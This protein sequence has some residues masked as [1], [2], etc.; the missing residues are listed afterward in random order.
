[1]KAPR[2]Q[3]RCGATGHRAGFHPVPGLAHAWLFSG[4]CGASLFVHRVNE[5]LTVGI[6]HTEAQA[7]NGKPSNLVIYAALGGTCTV[8]VG[9]QPDIFIMLRVYVQ[10]S[11]KKDVL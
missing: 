9:A 4:H 6:F 8:Q 2:P 11:K 10:F 5:H 7:K 3:A 1:M